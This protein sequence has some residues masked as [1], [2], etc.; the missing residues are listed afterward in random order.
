LKNKFLGENFYISENNI[1]CV[2]LAPGT[3]RRSNT[4]C[5]DVLEFDRGPKMRVQVETLLFNKKKHW[6]RNLIMNALGKELMER[7]VYGL[8]ESAFG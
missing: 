7:Q 8:D 4:T 6:E 5:L 1:I 2:K 3:T